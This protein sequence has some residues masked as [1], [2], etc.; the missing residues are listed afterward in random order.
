MIIPQHAIPMGNDSDDEGFNDQD[1]E[2]VHEIGDTSNNHH[3]DV[4]DDGYGDNYEHENAYDDEDNGEDVELD[5]GEDVELD[6]GEFG[7][8][9][10]IA[11]YILD[12]QEIEQTIHLLDQIDI[13]WINFNSSP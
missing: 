13:K 1:H 10:D 9:D 6:D 4:L 3:N 8:Y 12:Q 5:D 11:D 7:D 2:T